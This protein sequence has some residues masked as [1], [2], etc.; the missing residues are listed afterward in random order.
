MRSMTTVNQ[1]AARRGK[2]SPSEQGC[3]LTQDKHRAVCTGTAPSNPQQT[4]A[5]SYVSNSYFSFPYAPTTFTDQGACSSAAKACSKDYDACVTKL[6]DGSAYGVTINV[7]QGGGKTVDGSGTNVGAQA[8]SI[9]SSL[10]SEACPSL[11]PTKCASYGG[12][13]GT[14]SISPAPAAV[15][16]LLIT[17]SVLLAT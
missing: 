5:P 17:L 15:A 7:P 8:T 4:A 6:Q 16:A 14:P 10:S 3:E 2:S 12:N 11:S 13:S 9:C 1:H